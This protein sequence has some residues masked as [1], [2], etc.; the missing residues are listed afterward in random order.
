MYFLNEHIGK[1]DIFLYNFAHH[2]ILTTFF[3][4]NIYPFTYTSYILSDLGTCST[5]ILAL[6]QHCTDLPSLQEPE[7]RHT[8]YILFDVSPFK[9]NSPFFSLRDLSPS[10][11][12]GSKN[13]HWLTF[14]FVA[15]WLYSYL[16]IRHPRNT[17]IKFINKFQ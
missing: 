13:D 15:I 16:M 7:F 11:S 5:Y 4:K 9:M 12:R 17:F 14:S 8:T 1:H 3:K 6:K 10:E 2:V